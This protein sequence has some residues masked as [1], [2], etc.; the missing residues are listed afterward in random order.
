MIVVENLSVRAG[1]FALSDV[2]FTVAAGAYAVL[3]GMT[4][5]GKTTILEAIC[6][7]KPIR[8]GRIV[9]HDRDV[10]LLRPADR[11]VG[12]VPQDRAL[13]STMTVRDHLAFAP[14][15]HR[16]ESTAIQ[17][18]VGE[19]AE[20]LGIAHLLERRPHGLSG[21]EAQRVALG[22][23]LAIRPGVLLLDEP[24]SALDEATR[25][26]M[27]R[28]LETVRKQ[29]R[30]TVLHV[31]HS[32]LEAQRLADRVLVLERGSIVADLCPRDEAPP[33]G[34]RGVQSD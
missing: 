12:Y 7:L 16:W 20:L 14:V 5:S 26:D 13:F 1:A 15:V 23:A 9:L 28:L 29:T 19:L 10:T 4:G 21:G 8:G 30:V 31:T 2:S 27:C 18:R 6:G 34:A 17:A 3:M 33:D 25:E 32:V 24:L 11:G 22:R